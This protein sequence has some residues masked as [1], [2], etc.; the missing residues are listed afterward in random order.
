M[1]TWAFIQ[2]R[3]NSSRLPH[4]PFALIHG[5]PL[6]ERVY[7]QVRRCKNLD[8]IAFVITVNPKDDVLQS[9]IEKRSLP[10]Y[11]GSENDIVDR[12]LQASHQFGAD[13][14]VR[15]WGDCPLVHH[16]V[17]ERMLVEHEKTGADMTT[18]S[19]P[20]TF[21]FGLNVEIYNRSALERIEAGSADPFFREFPIEFIKK[22][23]EMKLLNVSHP[24]DISTIGLTVDYE[25]D[26]ILIE[27]LY[28]ELEQNYPDWS[29]QNL[30]QV[31]RA[32]TEWFSEN[33]N[34]KRNIDFKEKL[35]Q[36][37]QTPASGG[38]S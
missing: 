31:C 30:I 23:A 11:R 2:T 36:R 14:V 10:F 37:S 15:I 1:K 29:L 38:K 21:P 19:Q 17:I 18:N 20:P 28:A 35:E 7:E 34:L 25:T 9:D 27:K 12:F 16:E 13:R 32:R 24:E 5:K 6:L 33:Q 26:R 22:N 8:G 3:M 4:K